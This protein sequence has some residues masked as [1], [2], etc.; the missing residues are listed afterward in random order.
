MT[1]TT[2]TTRTIRTS[3][4]ADGFERTAEER[5]QARLER[6]RGRDGAPRGGDG[7]PR[8]PRPPRA[9]RTGRPAAPRRRP[10]APPR[11]HSW[12][13]RILALLILVVAAAA[14]WFLVELFQPFHGSP[15]GQVSVT[16]PAHST[17]S[18]VGDELAHA[19]VVSSG[20][21]F[22]LRA[23]L[24]GERGDLR[25]GTSRL[26]VGMSSGAGQ[27][28]EHHDHRGPHPSAGRRPPAYAG[29]GGQLLR[30]PP[31]LATH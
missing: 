1:R 31:A 10:T 11:K 29:R 15:H 14:V 26:A 2:R 4:M 16:I 6:E 12:A 20:F 23:T 18:A 5:E 8:P 19:G 25:A 21:F 24:S 3:A 30:R 22:E 27:G 9:V 17:A 7:A 28:D 13:G